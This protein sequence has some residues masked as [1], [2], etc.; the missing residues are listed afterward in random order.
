MSC[1]NLQH[2]LV[3]L[4]SLS[5]TLLFKFPTL[6]C[7]GV[8]AHALIDVCLQ[9]FHVL[10]NHQPRQW[11]ISQ[12]A[13]ETPFA[14]YYVAAITNWILVHTQDVTQPQANGAT[15]SEYANHVSH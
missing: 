11:A 9:T 8:L 14:K 2:K 4:K 1:A 3:F 5:D 6:G 10:A 7:N 12:I 13:Q 15:L